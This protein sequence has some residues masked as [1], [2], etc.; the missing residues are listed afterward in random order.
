M[1]TIDYREYAAPPIAD[2]VILS[3]FHAHQEQGTFSVLRCVPV[4][5]CSS[6]PKNLVDINDLPSLLATKDRL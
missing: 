1:R 2:N 5:G 4:A 3:V 6:G